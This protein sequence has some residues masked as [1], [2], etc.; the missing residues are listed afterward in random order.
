MSKIT[1]TQRVECQVESNLLITNFPLSPQSKLLKL[2]ILN[3]LAV[4]LFWHKNIL[5]L[6]H[7]DAFVP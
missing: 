4:F 3:E 5:N 2:L 1:E 6:G 7:N